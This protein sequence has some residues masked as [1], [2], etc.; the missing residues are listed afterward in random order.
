MPILNV[1]KIAGLMLGFKFSDDQLLHSSKIRRGKSY[2]KSINPSSS[3]I[4]TSDTRTKMSLITGSVITNA[5]GIGQNEVLIKEFST[6][7]ETAK[8]YGVNR[9][10][11]QKYAEAGKLWDNE[12]LFKMEFKLIN[13]TKI[14]KFKSVKPLLKNQTI[15]SRS[16]HY[17]VEI[18]DKN[19]ILVNKFDSLRDAAS[20]LKITRN[21][22]S[23]NTK[24]GKLWDNLYIFKIHSSSPII[25]SIISSIIS[26]NL[27]NI[28]PSTLTSEAYGNATKVSV[29]VFDS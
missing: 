27:T 23:N 6:I 25:S 10:T 5:E 22:I 17:L 29:Q 18:F 14:I 9:I 28:S 7:S 1:N 2:P 21:T 15:P 20:Y 11:I 4:I 8:F 3:I 24:S 26:T 19:Q 12:F 16:N 13:S